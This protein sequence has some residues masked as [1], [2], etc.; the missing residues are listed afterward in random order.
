MRHTSFIHDRFVLNTFRPRCETDGF[1]STVISDRVMCILQCV[2]GV[3]SK[4]GAWRKVDDQ[5]SDRRTTESILQNS[6]E[7]RIPVRYPRLQRISV[8]HRCRGH[9]NAL[10]PCL[11]SVLLGRE[12][13]AI[14]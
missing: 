9:Y 7:F 12:R 1:I 14:C 2:E 4:L 11:T 6:S 13:S 8:V 5:Q 10:L 3:L